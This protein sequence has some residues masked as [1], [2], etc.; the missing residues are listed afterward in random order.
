MPEISPGDRKWYLNQW[1][2]LDLLTGSPRA[3]P[4]SFGPADT[5]VY[6]LRSR[7]LSA[8]AAGDTLEARRLLSDLRKRSSTWS[9]RVD[10]QL[11]EGFLDWRGRRYQPVI[12]RLGH[13]A[14]SRMFEGRVLVDETS[15]PAQWLVS[16]SWERLGQPDSAIA[17]CEQPLAW[18]G[19]AGFLVARTL[20]QPFA[21][22][23]LVMLET[24]LGRLA[25][26]REHWQTLEAMATKPDAEF[27]P[28]LDDAHRALTSAEAMARGTSPESGRR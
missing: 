10:V 15:Y 2:L 19:D 9:L 27:R 28:L 13:L 11:A 4:Y 16:Q 20:T 22:Q 14:R 5:S 21:L 8:A 12:D 25:D 23:R 17:Y 26:A 18:G 24:R 7:A 3:S 6:W 1:L